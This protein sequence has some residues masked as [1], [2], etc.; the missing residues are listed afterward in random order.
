VSKPNE[1]SAFESAQAQT[2]RDLDYISFTEGWRA[3][4]AAAQPA[5]PSAT[6]SVSR[7]TAEIIAQEILLTLDQDF[8]AT[9]PNERWADAGR[10]V[11]DTIQQRSA[12]YAKAVQ[13][14]APSPS[15]AE[16]AAKAEWN[17]KAA[18][19]YIETLKTELS[20]EKEVVQVDL[21][22][23]LA[24]AERALAKQAPSPTPG[25]VERDVESLRLYAHGY[26]DTCRS[27]AKRDHIK[28]RADAY[29]ANLRGALPAQGWS[30]DPPTK[31]GWYWLYSRTCTHDERPKLLSIEK[32]DG[33][34]DCGESGWY[35][36]VVDDYG[37]EEPLED[38][39][40]W[41]MPASVPTPPNAE[42]GERSGG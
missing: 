14:K 5:G 8:G 24:E 30:K 13:P 32:L 1:E 22:E 33:E 34:N 23:R 35:L 36:G 18:E 2:S 12:E 11:A 19:E 28:R 31:P 38:Y 20:W 4:L 16:K 29:A 7:N 41:W 39:V 37:D 9:V 10:E 27:D 6:E 21:W 40:G 25:E 42:P 15:D 26:A 17:L 3:A